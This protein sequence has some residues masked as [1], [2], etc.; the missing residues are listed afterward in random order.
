[1]K[2]LLAATT[3]S[4]ANRRDIATANPA[5]ERERTDHTNHLTA[6]KLTAES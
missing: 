5:P 3:V 2:D 4:N 6:E 1:M